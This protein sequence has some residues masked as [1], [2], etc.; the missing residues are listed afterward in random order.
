M[1]KAD[2]NKKLVE[3]MIIIFFFAFC[4]L[5]GVSISCE[6]NA[7][8]KAEQQAKQEALDKAEFA[9][10]PEGIA[11]AKAEKARKEKEALARREFDIRAE[12]RFNLQQMAKD[13]SSV[14]F[15]NDYAKTKNG[16][17]VICGEINAKNGFG[18]YGGFQRFISNGNP[19]GTFYEENLKDFNQAWKKYC[20]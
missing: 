18:A 8:Q 13:P 14:K 5:I 15:R 2:D 6:S 19:D 9:K 7:K 1:N 10:T 4:V 17:T 20:I 3:K 12:A 11:Q 16:H